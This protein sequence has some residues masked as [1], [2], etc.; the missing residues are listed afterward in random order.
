VENEISLEG[1]VATD[2]DTLFIGELD[3]PPLD[4]FS[5][6]FNDYPSNPGF[7]VTVRGLLGIDQ[8]YELI[9]V[10]RRDISGRYPDQRVRGLAEIVP[11]QNEMRVTDYEA[12]LNTVLQYYVRLKQVGGGTLDLGPAIPVPDP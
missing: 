5:V 1:V 12:P 9:D 11:Q 7:V 3:R 4:E 2:T 8:Q 6:V 10:F